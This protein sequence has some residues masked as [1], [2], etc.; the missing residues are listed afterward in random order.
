MAL[1]GTLKDFGIA[2]ILQLIGQQA[3]SGVLHL[4]SRDDEI[5]VQMAEG[6]VIRAECAARKAKDK[7]GEL[8]VRAGLVSRDQLAAALEA[9]KRT[10]RRLGDILVEQGAISKESLKEM[11]A[12]QTTE[13]LY[14]LF[15]W[16][17][18]TYQFE[19]APIEWSRDTVEP[20]RAESVLMEG[21][22]QV[23]EWP[24]IRRKITSE[25]MT[26]RKGTP[27][28]EDDL[29]ALGANE[30]RVYPLA[31]AGATVEQIVACSRLGA[32]EACRALLTLVNHGALNPVSPPK[33]T[34]AQ[35]VGAYARR[36]RQRIRESAVRALLTVSLA[37]ALAALGYRATEMGLAWAAP[38]HS[39]AVRGNAVERFLARAQ[40]A[41]LG[42]AL[43]IY[44]LERGEYPE[45]LEMLA[46]AGVVSRDDLLRPW[47]KSYHY[48]RKPEGGYVLLPPVE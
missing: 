39:R 38:G 42:G 29:A 12:L 17:S 35:E 34:A 32:F 33:R 28:K 22:R 30:Q 48:R 18:G 24:M 36:W 25:A 37:V 40:M 41:R 4:K 9:Q 2:E 26:F 11:T 44:R 23:D 7:L 13:T 31:V 47:T 43:E 15:L 21:Y 19:P 5:H 14:R 20:L 45:R 16:K 1:Q 3:K 46:E 8:L 6:S 27:I 10:L